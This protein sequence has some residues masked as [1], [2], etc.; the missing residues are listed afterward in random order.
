MIEINIDQIC[1]IK[2]ESNSR[3][4]AFMHLC[5]HSNL[6]TAKDFY[7]IRTLPDLTDNVSTMSVKFVKW[8]R[9]QKIDGTRIIHFLDFNVKETKSLIV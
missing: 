8:G 1:D 6:Q 7:Q 2:G 9:N 3:Q 4:H 5:I